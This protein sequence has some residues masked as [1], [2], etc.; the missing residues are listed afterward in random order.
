[1]KLLRATTQITRLFK[2]NDIT[3]AFLMDKKVNELFYLDLN[4]Q[5]R[6]FTVLYRSGW[7]LPNEKEINPFS[8]ISRC[9][10]TWKA[11]W[12]FLWALEACKKPKSDL[13]PFQVLLWS[14]KVPLESCKASLIANN[15]DLLEQPLAYCFFKIAIKAAIKTIQTSILTAVDLAQCFIWRNKSFSTCTRVNHHSFMTWTLTIGLRG[16][17]CFSV[18]FKAKQIS[19]FRVTTKTW[20]HT[21]NY[22]SMCNCDGFIVGS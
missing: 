14:F 2:L 19:K 5:H 1:M 7:G 22:Q 17:F 3:E 15:R 10:G 11:L 20:R 12:S 21:H 13:Q 18:D 16:H 4:V 8:M 6:V 9:A